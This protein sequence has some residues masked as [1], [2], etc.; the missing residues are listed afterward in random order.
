[1]KDNKD[2][3]TAPFGKSTGQG[4]NIGGGAAK[5]GYNPNPGGQVNKPTT[6]TPGGTTNLNRDKDKNLGGQ[7]QQKT[8]W[9]KEDQNK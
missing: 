8:G 5:G 6:Q 3:T 4:A 9:K 2:K 7:Q 1:M